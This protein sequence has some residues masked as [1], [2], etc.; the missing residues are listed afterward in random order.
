ML[1]AWTQAWHTVSGRVP[2]FNLPSIGGDTYNRTGRGYPA[3]QLR[4]KDWVDV[5]GEYR[6]DLLRNGLVGVVAF[7]NASTFSDMAGVYGAW[8]VGGGAG[9]RLKLDKHNR[10][11]VAM[12]LAWGRGRPRGFWFGLNEAF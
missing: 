4:G 2:Y 12:D 3:G 11:N 8:E 5:E 6:A 9:F 10:T 7:V 1:A